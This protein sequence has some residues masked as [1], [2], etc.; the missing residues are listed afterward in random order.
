MSEKTGE[1]K[2]PWD[3]EERTAVFGEAVI[4]LL[5][6][7]PREA[8][9]NRLILQLIGAS[10]SNGANYCEADEAVSR[11]DYKYKI[12]TCKKEARE[13]KHFLRM[14]ARAAPQHKD[15]ARK[16]WKEAKE[17]HLIFSK[18]Y[19]TTKDHLDMPP[20]EKADE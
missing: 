10:T 4:D 14:I 15:E 6:K 17:L 18:I 12:G 8:W 16:L 5:R 3:L 13:S 1:P 20:Q 9:I 7:I 19:R 2:K 11:R